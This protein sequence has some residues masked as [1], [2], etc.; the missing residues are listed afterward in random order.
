MEAESSLKC[1]EVLEKLLDE[2]KLKYCF[3]CGICTASCPMAELLGKSYNPRRLLERIMLSSEAVLASEELWLCAWCYSCSKH[4]PQALQ[5]PEVFLLMRRLAKEK[6]HDEAYERSLEKIVKDVPLPLVATAVC[7]HPERAGLKMEAVLEKIGH[8]RGKGAKREK[9]KA[10]E[11]ARKVAIIG[12]GPAGLSV[13]YELSL[14]GYAPTVFEVLSEVG[15]MLRKCIPQY[16]LPR[17]ILEKEIEFLIDSGVEIKTG[18][19]VGKD[20]SFEDLWRDGYEAVF[21]GVGVHKGQGLRIEGSDLNG[22]FHA[23]DFLW[24]VNSGKKVDLGNNVV[25]VGGGNVAVDAART[26]LKLGAN[27]VTILYRRS[28][29][30]MPAI[31]WEVKEAENE[32]VKIEFLVAPKRIL[33]ENGKVTAVECIRML[34][35]EPDESGRRKPVPIEGSEFKHEANMVILAIGETA[36]VSF[37]PKDIELNDDGTVWVNPITMETSI[38]GVFAGGDVATGP[39]T[40]IEAIRAGKTAAESI[41]CYLKS[42]GG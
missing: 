17:E 6:G 21:V 14:R 39:A 18:V 41:D 31:P 10:R 25:V 20:L 27:N 38:R 15:G 7:F 8:L 33:G 36:D 35:G 23:L 26:A 9:R 22:V 19:A 42:L 13:A 32:G 3:E 24:D 29:E 40:V 12:S 5:L 2:E 16:R 11:K 4:C 34:L 30:E 28:K 37:L 1:K